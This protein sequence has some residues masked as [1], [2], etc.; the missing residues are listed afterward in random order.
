[1]VYKLTWALPPKPIRKGDDGTRSPD[2]TPRKSSQLVVQKLSTQ[3]A[4]YEDF[5][6]LPLDVVLLIFDHLSPCSS[7]CLG[8]TCR[9]LYG[10]HSLS[11]EQVPLYAPTTSENPFLRDRR[12]GLQLFTLLEDW[13][14]ARYR[15]DDRYMTFRLKELCGKRINNDWEYWNSRSQRTHKFNLALGQRELRINGPPLAR[16]RTRSITIT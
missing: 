3:S 9:A 4:N 6:E 14:P 15:W 7:V 5:T 8:L 11:Y 13:M 12:R 2:F 1:M 16:T 10:V